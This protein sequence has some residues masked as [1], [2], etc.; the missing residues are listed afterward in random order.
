M[1][2]FI[3]LAIAAPDEAIKQVNWCPSYENKN[4]LTATVISSSVGGFQ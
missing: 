1:D 3:Q 2:R 4:D